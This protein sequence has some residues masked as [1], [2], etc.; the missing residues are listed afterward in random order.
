M[1]DE[2]KPK[3]AIT[4][5]EDYK[6]K[7]AITIIRPHEIGQNQEG[8]LVRVRGVFFESEL[9][10]RGNGYESEDGL[11]W[12]EAYPSDVIEVLL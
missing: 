7:R 5:S 12:Y 2:Y 9:V 6:P 11:R 4:I 3:R 10:L 8:L 1:S